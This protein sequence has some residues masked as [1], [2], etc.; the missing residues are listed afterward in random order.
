MQLALVEQTIAYIAYLEQMLQ[1]PD[2]EQ[3][4]EV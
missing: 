3:V 1:Q 4:C 2:T